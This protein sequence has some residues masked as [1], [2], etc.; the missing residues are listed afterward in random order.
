M[1]YTIRTKCYLE[2][3]GIINNVDYIKE[4]NV[5]NKY[6]SPPPA[7]SSIED[8]LTQFKK[9][10]KQ[11]H[12]LRKKLKGKNLSNL[13]K[14]QSKTVYTLKNDKDIIIKPTDKNLG[15]AVLDLDAYVRQILHEHLLKNDCKQLSK[16][17]ALQK[18]EN[19]KQTLKTMIANSHGILTKA[20]L[21]YF[22]CSF[23]L[24]HRLPVFYGLPKVYKNPVSLRP[25][26]SNTN[27]FL[28]VFSVWLDHKMKSLLPL[29][30]SY[31]KNSSTVIQDVKE[32]I[33][34]EGAKIFTADATSMYTNIDRSRNRKRKGPSTTISY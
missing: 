26:V 6:W 12:N 13:T 23:H 16:E 11:T 20:E 17:S 34:P 33:F 31:I 32:L 4:L 9:L 19:I 27:S 18:M 5:K 3:H 8:K 1:A 7:S 30:H 10:L 29:I 14:L 15:P 24:Q 25:V 2:K 28:A 21:V 22:Q